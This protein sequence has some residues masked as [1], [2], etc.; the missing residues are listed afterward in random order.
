MSIPSDPIWLYR[1]TH[2][3]NLPHI[4]EYGLVT[5][6]S[7]H[8]NKHF[9]QIGDLTMIATREDLEAPDPPG[10]KYSE[11]VPFYF[12]PRSPMLYQIA[13]GWEGIEKIPQEEI[14]YMVSSFQKVTD[15]QL[16]YFFTDGHARAKTSEKF[17]D[18][19]DL[20]KLDWAAIRAKQWANDDQDLRR[21]EKKQAEL[22][23]K[24]YVPME[25]IEHLAV[26]SY[27]AQRKV[28]DLVRA[29]GK[30]LEVKVDPVNLYYDHL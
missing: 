3:D 27:A 6:H 23:V 17:T 2:I 1:I 13:T 21:K 10:G 20:V 16:P 12:G 5:S 18:P 26:F 7:P 9:R 19:V 15:L 4:L 14:I 22:L 28:L 8:N 24:G 29:A 25:G 30:N 11:Y